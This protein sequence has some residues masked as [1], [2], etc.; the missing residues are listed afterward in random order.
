MSQRNSALAVLLVGILTAGSVAT[1]VADDWPLFRGPRRDG[2]SPATNVPVEFSRDKNVAWQ[3]ELPG[4]SNGSPIVSG[5]YVFVTCSTP[6]AAA[7]AAERPRA[8]PQ[9]ERQPGS[10]DPTLYFRDRHLL[11]FDRESGQRLWIQTIEYPHKEITHRTNPHAGSSP[12]ADGKHVVIWEGSAGAHCFN[13]QGQKL[14]SRDLG[15][16]NH[17]WG[18]GGSPVFY[19]N[20]A[21]INCGPGKRQFVIA[22]DLDSGQT[23]WQYDIPDGNDGYDGGKSWLGS[24]STPVLHEVDGRTQVLVTL[25]GRLQA[26]DPKTGE[27]LWHVEGTGP[28]AY[29]DPMISGDMA[30]ATSGFHGPALATRLGGS[31]DMT[32]SSRLWHDTSRHPQRIGTGIIIGDYLYMANAE[33]IARCLKVADGEEVWKGRLGGNIWS[34]LVLVED[35]FYVTSQN[36][37][38]YVFAANPEEFE[39][40]AENDMGEGSNSTVAVSDGQLFL[41]TFTHLY[42]I[43]QQA[44]Q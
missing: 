43:E 18:Y 29:N 26:L 40:L 36:G 19:E 32:E 1:A 9:Q 39:L 27:L 41:R 4:E 10:G 5:N 11:C 13:Y 6:N 44:G 30:I 38:T 25:Q 12:A 22:L 23:L 35:R 7:V 21:I 3:A 34:S 42:C 2:K 28:L 15:K 20:S 24:W 16:F 31:G 14:W 33:G 17:I 8:E 37:T